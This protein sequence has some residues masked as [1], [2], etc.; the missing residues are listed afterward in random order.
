MMTKK[1]RQRFFETET[2]DHREGGVMKG[3]KLRWLGIVLMTSII[4]S[5]NE[6]IDKLL[7]NYRAESDLSKITRRDS[8]GIISLYTRED[9][10]Q[11]QARTLLDILRTAPMVGLTRSSNNLTLLFKP[12]IALLPPSSIRLYINDHDMTSTS[13]GSAMLIWGDMPVELIDHIEIYKGASSIEFGNEPGIL[14]IRLYTKTALRDE[15]GKI[16]L[17]WGDRGSMEGSLYVAHTTKNDLKIFGFADGFDVDAPK[18]Q[19]VYGTIRDNRNGGMFYADIQYEGWRAEGG[20]YQK[21]QDNFLG[22]LRNHDGGLDAEH[23]YLHLSKAEKDDYKIQISYDVIEY[24]R[25]YGGGLSMPAGSKRVDRYKTRFNDNIFNLSAEK[26]F[27]NGSNRLMFGAF[28][29]HKHF[30]QEG[31]F[32]EARTHQALQSDYGS[33][34]NLYSVY[35][36]NRYDISDHNTVIVSLKGDYYDYEDEIDND[37]QWIGR[38]GYLYNWSQWHFKV[39]ATHTYLTPPFYKLYS[40]HRFPYRS[41][42]DLKAPQIDMLESVIGYRYDNHKLKLVIG[43]R[44]SKERIVYSL[45]KGPAYVNDGSWAHD[46]IASLEYESNFNHKHRFYASIFTGANDMA[47]KAPRY[48][49]IL[50]FYDRF[51]PIDLYNELGWFSHYDYK[52][53]KETTLH[54]SDALNYTAALTWHAGEDLSIALKGEN[55]F[56]SGFK[57]AYPGYPEAYPVNERKFWLTLEYLF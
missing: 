23:T 44:Q 40:P 2:C 34:L 19:D 52:T 43:W 22:F 25:Q 47:T 31:S 16:K 15:G 45:R 29:K 1:V 32:R 24:E 14:I 5:A 7:A 10:E 41:N 8:A 57:Q 38:I 9:L 48:G 13:F 42:P 54:M 37:F 35:A 20:R 21:D 12:T 53:G 50:R 55:L 17:W 51:G 6:S 18:Y 4:V 28:Y 3:Y 30:D 11:M 46:T 56:D 33:G 26:I 36:E 49:A 39:F 27:I